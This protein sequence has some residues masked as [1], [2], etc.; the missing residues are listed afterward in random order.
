MA[1]CGASSRLNGCVLPS[2]HFDTICGIF[3]IYQ[4]GLLNDEIIRHD[5]YKEHD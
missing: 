4:K 5:M 2:L 1:L 3:L